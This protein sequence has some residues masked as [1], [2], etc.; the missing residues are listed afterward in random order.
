MG[1]CGRAIVHRACSEETL[2]FL[3]LFQ[4]EI[5]QH[6]RAR[7]RE[8]SKVA[9]LSL[10]LSLSLSCSLQ[11]SVALDCSC[12]LTLS[13]SHSSHFP[14]LSSPHDSSPLSD[15]SAVSPTPTAGDPR[16]FVSCRPV[17]PERSYLGIITCYPRVFSSPKK[18][19]RKNLTR[20]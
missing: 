13:S 8:S 1:W 17:Y 12:V 19:P 7:K 14:S 3:T 20:R 15:P 10:S 16:L 11:F 5:F 2:F 6:P 9:S 4:A 18:L